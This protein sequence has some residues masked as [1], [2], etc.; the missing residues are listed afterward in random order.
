MGG[1]P[2]DVFEM[3]AVR[4]PAGVQDRSRSSDAH[5]IKAPALSFKRPEGGYASALPNVDL[6]RRDG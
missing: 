4:Q 3:V 5:V 6:N 2:A 1:E